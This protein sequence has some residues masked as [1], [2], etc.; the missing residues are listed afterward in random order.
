MSLIRCLA[1]YY[2]RN[3]RLPSHRRALSNDLTPSHSRSLATF[4]QRREVSVD[5]IDN[6]PTLPSTPQKSPFSTWAKWA[7]GLI[8]TILLPFGNKKLLQIENEVEM[9]ENVVE[10]AAVVVEKVANMTEKVS[11]EVA[12]R[13]PEDGKLK[14]A[15]V[16][17]EHAS[18]EVAEEAHLAQDI[19]HKVD[20]LEEEVKTLLDP[21]THHGKVS[22]EKLETN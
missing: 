9:V 21:I 17:V 16:F 20:E 22:N 2:R 10:N 5:R 13:L 12:E 1:S 15:V 8:T 11:S 7:I 4:D 14:D 18:K 6:K 3:L 19:I